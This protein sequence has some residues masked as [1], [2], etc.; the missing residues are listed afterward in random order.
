MPPSVTIILPV[1]DEA[2]HLEACLASLQAQDYEGSVEIVVADGGSTDGS[3]TELERRQAAGELVLVDNPQRRQWAGLNR[4]AERASGEI[5]V[6][7]DGHSTY[8]PDYVSRSVAAL[9]GSGVTAA[10][11]R[12]IPA[13]DSPVGRA[14]VSAMASRW[15]VGPAR[16]RHQDHPSLVDTVYLG[17]FRRDDFHRLGGFRDLPGVAEDADL[18][19]RWRRQGATVLLDPSIKSDY[20]P[21]ESWRAL[22][23]QYFRYGWGKADM[24][25][26]NRVLPS[27]RPLAPLALVVGLIAG[28]GLAAAGF[29]WPPAALL[30]AWL[31]VLILVASGAGPPIAHRMRTAWATALMQLA[32]GAGLLLGLLRGPGPRRHLRQA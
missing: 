9:T 22:S 25:Y 13:S 2:D 20:R 28:I 5:L 7:V 17:A 30:A 4:A 16:Y 23:R 32:Y 1:L 11:G 6:R 26:A 19:F 15:A 8:A 14:V 18:Y 21:R 29:Y 3:R 27:L 31:I 10:G 24:V 12:M